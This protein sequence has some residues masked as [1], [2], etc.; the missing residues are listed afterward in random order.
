MRLNKERIK[1]ELDKRQW[2]Y[3]RLALEIGVTKQGLSIFM[4]RP[5]SS[6]KNVTKIARVFDIDEKDLM[7]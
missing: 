7:I 3:Q 1:Y 5:L 6:I 2:T 4:K